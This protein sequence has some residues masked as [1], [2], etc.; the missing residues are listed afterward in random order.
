MQENNSDVRVR[1]QVGVRG[2]DLRR[3]TGSNLSL[4]FK[5]G[6]RGGMRV[7]VE[8]TCINQR[9]W[10]KPFSSLYLR[11]LSIG[12]NIIYC[13]TKFVTY[14]CTVIQVIWLMSSHFLSQ[15]FTII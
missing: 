11:G 5:D 3:F 6:G 1:G 7:G 15:F 9:H 14:V 13:L 4:P 12:G 8:L 10:R 2:P